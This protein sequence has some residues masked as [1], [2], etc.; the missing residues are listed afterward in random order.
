MNQKLLELQEEGKIVGVE[1]THT[2]RIYVGCLDTEAGFERP[3]AEIKAFCADYV[4]DVGLCVNV[5]K[6]WFAYGDDGEGNNEGGAIV[7]LIQYPRFPKAEK[8]ITKQA[9]DLGERLIKRMNQKRISVICTD[10]T[11]TLQN[12]NHEEI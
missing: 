2:A 11:Y 10:Q 3:V 4:K 12:P 1:P 6:T 7:E 8:D 5:Q 9:L